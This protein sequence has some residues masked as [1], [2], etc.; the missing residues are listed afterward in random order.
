MARPNQSLDEHLLGV[1]QHG[2]EIARF[3]PRFEQHLPRLGRRKRLRQRAQHAR[4]R[5]QDRA[6]DLA[7]GMRERSREHGA[8]IVNMASTGCGKTLGNARIMYALADPALGMR[9]AFA[10]GIAHP[11]A[12]NRQG[13][14]RHAGAER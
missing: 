7:G 11:D 1:A 9:C 13:V 4:F 2:A 5:W 12:A 8:F 3:L 10:H 6:S 14:P